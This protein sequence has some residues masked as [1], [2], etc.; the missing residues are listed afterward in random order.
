MNLSQDE[1]RRVVLEA[2]EISVESAGAPPPVGPRRIE[3]EAQGRVGDPIEL[4]DEDAE[5]IAREAL[6]FGIS[7]VSEADDG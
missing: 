3:S 2:F 6:L 7:R 4:S 5:E 1:A